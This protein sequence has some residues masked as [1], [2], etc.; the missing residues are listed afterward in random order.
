MFAVSNGPETSVE[1]LASGAR[2]VRFADTIPMSTYLVAFVVGPLEATEPVDVDGIP[3]RVVTVP[4]KGH[5]TATAAEIAAH[6]LRYFRDYFGIPYPGDK[7]D[8][9]AI[10]DFAVGADG[11]PRLRHVPRGGAPRRSDATRPSPS[12]DGS[13]RSSSTSSPTCGSGTSSRCAG[14]TASG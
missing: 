9:V 14:G 8:L 1:Q 3:L 11:E 12:C 7:L 10:P 6:A 2:R 13:P 4:G 5:L